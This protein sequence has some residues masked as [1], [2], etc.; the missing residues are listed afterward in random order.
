MRQRLEKD[1]NKRSCMRTQSFLLQK[2]RSSSMPTEKTVLINL[3]KQLELTK[4][5]CNSRIGKMKQ[6]HRQ[7]LSDMEHS[8]TLTLLGTET[9][10]K[11]AEEQLREA[12]RQYASDMDENDR[13]I[14]SLEKTLRQKTIS[15][16]RQERKMSELRDRVTSL[17]IEVVNKTEEIETVRSENDLLTHKL[18]NKLSF[19]HDYFNVHEDIISSLSTQL[20]KTRRMMIHSYGYNLSNV[21]LQLTEQISDMESDAFALRQQLS[22]TQLELTNEAVEMGK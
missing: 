11:R 13:L 15:I 8:L 2:R 6:T 5:E 17:E 10:V 3:S 14:Q 16:R 4:F 9:V 21:E 1:L 22:K 12:K 18:Q 19:E 20:N 7:V